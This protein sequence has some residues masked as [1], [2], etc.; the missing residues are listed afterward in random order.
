MILKLKNDILH[1]PTKKFSFVEPP[2][3]PTEL[4]QNL[5][6]TMIHHRGVGL[7]AP[8]VGIPYSVFVM[9]NPDDPD[10]IFS[11]FNPLIVDEASKDIVLGEEGC[12]SFPNLYVKVKRPKSIKARFSGHDGNVG[13]LKMDGWTARIFQHEFDHLYGITFQKR[14]SKFHLD[15]AKNKQKKMK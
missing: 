13:T 11:V 2:M 7:A 5:K 9:G 1:Q 14:A 8:Q 10:S 12:L 15:Q 3:D 4:F 6:E